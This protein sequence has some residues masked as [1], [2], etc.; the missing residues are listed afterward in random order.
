[1]SCK[2][3]VW[4]KKVIACHSF[5]KRR[6]HTY[7]VSTSSYQKMLHCRTKCNCH[8]FG[9][10]SLDFK[11]GIQRCPR[12]PAARTLVKIKETEWGLNTDIISILSSPTLARI[13]S[14][15]ACQ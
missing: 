7:L 2:T 10:V 1:M 6:L 3:A 4:E 5:F 14:R 11:F 15:L 12:I 9:V 13:F 8:N